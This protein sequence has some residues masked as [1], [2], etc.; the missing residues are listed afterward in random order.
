M[1]AKWLNWPQAHDVLG[2]TGLETG[3]KT[4]WQTSVNKVTFVLKK[5]A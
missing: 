5:K 2:I 4:V 3:S 1:F